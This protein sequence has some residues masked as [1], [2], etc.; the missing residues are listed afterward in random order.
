MVLLVVVLLA[1]VAVLMVVLVVV[2][3]VV[4]V[5]VVPRG[6]SME[7]R[8]KDNYPSK[9]GPYHLKHQSKGLKLE[10]SFYRLSFST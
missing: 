1:L 3:I 5:V 7:T 2:V 9:R 8:L 10:N 6:P 4:I